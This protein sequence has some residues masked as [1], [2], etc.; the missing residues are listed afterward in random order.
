MHTE[1]ALVRCKYF[2]QVVF[3]FGVTVNMLHCCQ[4][5]EYA[6]YWV[7]PLA[8]SLNCTH[9]ILVTLLHCYYLLVTT[10]LHLYI[11]IYL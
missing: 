6:R 10:C 7:A 3:I 4:A 5:R 11:Y 2:P 8:S 1:S 9:L